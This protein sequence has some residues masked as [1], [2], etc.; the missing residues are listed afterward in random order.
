MGSKGAGK[1]KPQRS[2]DEKVHA[3]EVNA[4]RKAQGKNTKSVASVSRSKA[5]AQAHRARISQPVP[6]ERI[7]ATVL[8]LPEPPAAPTWHLASTSSKEGEVLPSEQPEETD[9]PNAEDREPP[10]QMEVDHSAAATC[11]DSPVT[12][13]GELL[14]T[15]ATP[16]VKPR[17]PPRSMGA[18]GLPDVPF[19]DF[20]DAR[21]FQGRRLSKPVFLASI[22]LLRG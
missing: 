18:S 13:S 3:K 21:S 9:A 12:L 6:D 19:P 8:D 22:R 2:N 10:P 11:V 4:T 7:A 17:P 15:K 5:R 20:K 14:T 16:V 1:G